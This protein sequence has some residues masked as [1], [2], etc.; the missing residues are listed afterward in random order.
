MIAYFDCFSGIS[1]NMVLGALLDAGLNRK[2]LEKELGKLKL[3]GYGIV[4][5]KVK[6][7][8]IAGTYFNVKTKDYKKR[9]LRTIRQLIAKSG[10][11]SGVK[12][13]SMEI[14][15][16][17]ASAEAKAHGV[18]RDKV[19]FHEI[20][21]LDSIL[22]VAGCAAALS[23]MGIEEI[24]SSALNL[25]SGYVNCSHG[26]L[27]VPAP[28]T[29]ELLKGVAVYSSDVTGELVTPT[30]A[31]IIKYFSRRFGEMPPMS[32]DKVGMGA[33]TNDF[34]VPNFL[35]VFIGKPREQYASDTVSI[36]E[37]NLDDMNPQFYGYV[38][39]KLFKEGALD[40]FM[41]PV[42]MKKNRPGIALSVICETKD[43]RKMTSVIFGETTA[44]GLRI[45]ETKRIKLFREFRSIKTRYGTIRVKAG[46]DMKKNIKSLTPEYEDCIKAAA[47]YKIPLKK[48]YGEIEKHTT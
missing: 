16:M 2:L 24:Y 11:D 27:P 8:G 1:G 44:F 31:A 18:T 14:F 42:Y 41:T 25:G 19:H 17:L 34:K 45:K 38:F 36:L 26:I 13:K 39:E 29:A 7:N 48:V 46:M 40:V 21:D 37:T 43:V 47:K 15:E 23:V 4:V 30:G 9:S 12:K 6:K 32:Y 22:D 35:R 28:A 20:G 33:G 10:L 5:S 3:K